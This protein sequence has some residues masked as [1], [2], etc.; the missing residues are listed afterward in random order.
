MSKISISLPRLKNNVLIK[1]IIKVNK[2]LVISK[3]VHL[4]T[5]TTYYFHSYSEVRE[6]E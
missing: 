3:T 2:F 1:Y 6:A 4:N 5:L